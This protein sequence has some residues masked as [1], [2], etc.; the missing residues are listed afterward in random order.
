VGISGEELPKDNGLFTRLVPLQ[1][2]EYKRDRTWYEWFNRHA[3]EFSYLTLYLLLNY[4]KLKPKIMK[5]IADLK[6]AL[7]E[8]DISDRTAENWAIC[9]GSFEA[10]IFED[11]NFIR[12]VMDACQEAKLSGESEHM[13]N[14]FWND[15]SVLASRGDINS[16]H[17]AVKEN[18]FYLWLAGAYGEWASF[19]RSKTGREP[20]DE[21]SIR[22]Y[23]EDEPYFIRRERKEVFGSDQSQ[24]HHCVVIDMNMAPE[25]IEE[26]VEMASAHREEEERRG[27]WN[28]N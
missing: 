26:I 12:W 15:L 11:A 16:K 21:A 19:F 27:Y 7:V 17:V 5:N 3:S 2:S 10:A 24:R 20:F 23:M 4:K 8:K 28:D 14:Q 9:A 13:L 25:V 22:K 1:I 18:E 6:E